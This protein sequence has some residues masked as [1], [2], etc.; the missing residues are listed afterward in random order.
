MS[1]NQ[2]SSTNMAKIT[3]FPD[4][5]FPQ[6][7][8]YFIINSLLLL[9][10]QCTQGNKNNKDIY[11]NHWSGSKY[12]PKM[13]TIYA[14]IQTWRETVLTF[15]ESPKSWVL[16]RAQC[17]S[18]HGAQT[19][20]SH[21][22]GQCWGAEALSASRP[23]PWSAAAPPWS[24]CG[25]AVKGTQEVNEHKNISLS[26]YDYKV[27]VK[28]NIDSNRNTVNDLWFLERAQKNKASRIAMHV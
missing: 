25:P 6:E 5:S 16:W 3:K 14:N 24:V 7:T 17:T 20:R 4:A 11:V 28:K 21:R 9:V 19:P 26:R 23:P 8:W 13:V 1:S 2:M 27:I 22:S 18:C 10:I 15:W 12:H